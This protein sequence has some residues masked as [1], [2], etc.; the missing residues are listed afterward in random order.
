[1]H[2]YFKGNDKTIEKVKF[3]RNSK[4]E[5]YLNFAPQKSL[6]GVKIQEQEL[7]HATQPIDVNEMEES[8]DSDSV[9]SLYYNDQAGLTVYEGKLQDIKLRAQG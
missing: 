2:H 9:Q 7:L 8:L 5:H 3:N 4:N 1:M 6:K